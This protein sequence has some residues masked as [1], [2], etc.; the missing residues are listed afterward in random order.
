MQRQKS[1]ERLSLRSPS[2]SPS[3]ERPISRSHNLTTAAFE[4]IRPPS[5]QSERVS[6]R[7]GTANAERNKKNSLFMDAVSANDK[8]AISKLRQGGLSVE[9]VNETNSAG[10]TA[11]I[12]AALRPKEYES[13]DLVKIVVEMGGN[14]NLQNRE[15]MTA[16]MYATSK[17]HKET[18][19]LL[20]SSGA[21]VG[22]ET[23]VCLLRII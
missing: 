18:V 15:G 5:Q 9:E 12:F 2:K 7:Q 20:L 10:N 19:K 21:L 14:V 6:S 8:K 22:L 23:T 13:Y 16:L 1:K 3:K 11:L 17:S 4:E